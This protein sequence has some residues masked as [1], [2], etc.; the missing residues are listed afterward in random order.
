M[1]DDINVLHNVMALMTPTFSMSC[2]HRKWRKDLSNH[3]FIEV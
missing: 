2:V 3:I 1:R